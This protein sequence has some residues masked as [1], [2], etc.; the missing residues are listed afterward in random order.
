[1]SPKVRQKI[2]SKQIKLY[3]TEKL[4]HRKENHQQNETSAYK[5]GG[6]GIFASYI[7]DVFERKDSYIIYFIAVIYILELNL[8]RKET[9]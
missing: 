1:M 4:L 2:K 9:E 7:S 5:I 8:V 3:Q 6:G